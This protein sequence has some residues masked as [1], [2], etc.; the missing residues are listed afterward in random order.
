ML[1]LSLW[2]IPTVLCLL[3]SL[4]TLELEECRFSLTNDSI[5]TGR[6][7]QSQAQTLVDISTYTRC[8][9]P[10]LMI[11]QRVPLLNNNVVL[12]LFWHQLFHSQLLFV[13]FIRKISP[14]LISCQILFLPRSINVLV[15]RENNIFHL[16]SSVFI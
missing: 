4:S 1:S 9:G 16:F 14:G 6:S 12:K 5:L 10:F 11:Y 15:Y 2:K 13:L 8:F 3:S 7:N